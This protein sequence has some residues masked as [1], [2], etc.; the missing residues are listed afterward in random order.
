MKKYFLPT[1]RRYAML[2]ALAPLFIA[3]ACV[4]RQVSIPFEVANSYFFKRGQ[5]IPASPKITTAEEF[6]QLFGMATVMGPNGRPTDIDFDKQFVVA[7]VLPQTDIDTEILPV[8][9]EAKDDA[10]I[11]A[12]N[13]TTGEKQS[14][15]IQPLSLIVLDK[16]YENCE[17][18]LSETRSEKSE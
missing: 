18:I 16:K 10:L 15:T 3:T 13:V 5:T 6:G 14:F 7:I 1:L 17:I 12:Y 9:V 11:C 8:S 4:S 2:V